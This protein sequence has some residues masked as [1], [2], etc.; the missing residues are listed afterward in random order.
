MCSLHRPCQPCKRVRKP[1]WHMLG[2]DL[3]QYDPVMTTHTKS[4][5]YEPKVGL[6]RLRTN[7]RSAMSSRAYFTKLLKSMLLTRLPS[8][9]TIRQF[10][11]YTCGTSS[12]CPALVV[13]PCSIAT[14]PQ[15]NSSV[16][17][18]RPPQSSP[19]S[20][21][22]CCGTCALSA[23]PPPIARVTSG[24]GT[25]GGGLSGA[26]I[27]GIVGGSLGGVVFIAAVLT[28]VWCCCRRKTQADGKP[29]QQGALQPQR[30]SLE[31]PAAVRV[32]GTGRLPRPF[33]E[34]DEERMMNPNRD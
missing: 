6:V 12:G 25:D 5:T 24:N 8:L 18:L 19:L 20:D 34:V 13:S 14:P 15:T 22:L 10:S 11:G 1:R 4:S 29:R 27:A 31:K 21:L 32:P 9:Q 16:T 7:K 23:A 28:A 17:V 26:A 30:A 33:A 3:L 2:Y